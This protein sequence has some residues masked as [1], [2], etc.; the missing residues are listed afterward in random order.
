MKAELIGDILLRNCILKHVNE[1]KMEGRIE[2]TERRGSRRRE[3]LNDL[4]KKRG[5]WEFNTGHWSS[6]CAEFALEKP[7]DLS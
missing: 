1:G 4:K 2:V 6:F 7:L 5:C 3:L